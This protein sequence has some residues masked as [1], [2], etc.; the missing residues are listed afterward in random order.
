LAG[1]SSYGTWGE[2]LPT[3]SYS[4]Q[5]WKADNF[6]FTG[7]ESL[8]GTGFINFGARWYDNIVPR[9]TTIDPLAEK[10]D[11]ISSYNYTMN[12]P[13]LYTDPDGRDI[14]ITSQIVDGK[15]SFSINITGKIINDSKSQYTSEQLQEYANRLSSSIASAFTGSEGDVSWNA[16]V[17]ISVASKDNK[18]NATDHAFRITDQDKINEISETVDGVTHGYAP[19][20]ENVVYISDFLSPPTAN[21]K[22][23][24]EGEYVGTGKN[25][26]GDRTLERTGPHELGHSANLMHPYPQNSMNGNLMHPTRLPNAGSK[27][28]AEQ[29]L[30]IHTG[31]I[32]GKLNHGKQNK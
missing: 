28:T 12:N 18:L 5:S 27:V 3:L 2:D 31:Y 30:E 26:Y 22:P 21:N 13:V 24:L 14:N 17:D 19:Y 15:L 11:M 6:K 4:K 23:A 16:N 10:W 7:K 25:E 8:Q 9:F 20:G 1:K 32:N 29:V